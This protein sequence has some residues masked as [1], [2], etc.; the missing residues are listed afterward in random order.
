MKKLLTLAT[1]CLLV[2]AG[3]GSNGGGSS[4]G[5]LKVGVGGDIVQVGPGGAEEPL[6]AKIL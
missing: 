3:C 5:V 2:L 6:S 1:C 4:D